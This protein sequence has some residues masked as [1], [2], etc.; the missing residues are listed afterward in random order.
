MINAVDWY[1]RGAD[2]ADALHLAVSNNALM[3]TFDHAFC[4]AA[5]EAGVAP[6]VCILGR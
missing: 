6:D 3:H 1:R 2:F 4:K 5:R